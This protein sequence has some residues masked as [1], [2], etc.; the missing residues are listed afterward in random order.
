MYQAPV[1]AGRRSL[2]AVLAASV[3][4][5]GGA[6]N[7]PSSIYVT[8]AGYD[9]DP[10]DL[11]ADPARCPRSRRQAK[12]NTMSHQVAGRYHRDSRTSPSR[13]TASRYQLAG[14]P[15]LTGADRGLGRSVPA[16]T[17]IT[18][19]DLPAIG[20]TSAVVPR[21]R[22]EGDE[23]KTRCRRGR[24]RHEGPSDRSRPRARDVPHS[25][26]KKPYEP[27]WRSRAPAASATLFTSMQHSAALISVWPG[28]L[29]GGSPSRRSLCRRRRREE[30]TR[31]LTLTWRA[32][33]A[34]GRKSGG[35]GRWSRFNPPGR[36]FDPSVPIWLR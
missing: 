17:T 15:Q 23:L 3:A 32:P 21:T 19:N 5:A 22:A 14:Q 13:R 10:E 11:A 12:L 27:R 20:N 33:V 2:A 9:H 1:R 8:A 35:F 24:R 28:L 16:K 7:Q 25:H 18:A 30:V 31:S 29:S 36:I 26:G 34:Q 4:A 6:A